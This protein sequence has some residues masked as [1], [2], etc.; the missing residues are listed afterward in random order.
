MASDKRIVGKLSDSPALAVVLPDDTIPIRQTDR[1]FGRPLRTPLRIP[2]G[3]E[4]T[5]RPAFRLLVAADNDG[6]GVL[7][8]LKDL[9]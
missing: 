3:G 6:S 8:V 2:A 7:V 9:A 1:F 5:L 4:T